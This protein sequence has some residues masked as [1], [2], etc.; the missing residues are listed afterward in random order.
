[1]ASYSKERRELAEALERRALRAPLSLLLDKMLA[2]TGG[3]LTPAERRVALRPQ[4][5]ASG[6]RCRILASRSAR[7]EWA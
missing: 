4:I 6:T 3:A 7:S 5:S 2:E 1:M